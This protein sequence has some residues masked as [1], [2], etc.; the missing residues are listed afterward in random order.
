MWTPLDIPVSPKQPFTDY[1]RWRLRDTDDGRHIW[2]FLRSEDELAAR[3]SSEIDKY[4]L[5]L[6][7]V[8]LYSV[9]EPSVAENAS[10]IE[11]PGTPGGQEPV[12]RCPQRIHIL[13]KASN[14]RRSLG[15]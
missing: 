12:G 15:G 10:C 11:F 8:S 14:K 3:P 6:P 13:Q 2:D 9:I 4:W 7:L 5:G 1:T